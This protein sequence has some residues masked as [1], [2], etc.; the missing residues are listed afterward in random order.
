MGPF[1]RDSIHKERIDP[2]MKAERRRIDPQMTQIKR[3]LKKII[4]FY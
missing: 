2:Q 1:G 3:K 4:S